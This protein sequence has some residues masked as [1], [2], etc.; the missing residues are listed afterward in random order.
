MTNS[1]EE[2]DKSPT[3]GQAVDDRPTTELSLYRWIVRNLGITIPHK[4]V[5][6]GHTSPWEIFHK[7]YFERPPLALIL[8]PRGGGKSYLSA[9]NI[10]LTSKWNSKHS[11][12]VL[13]GSLSQSEQI[14]NALGQII[15][16]EEDRSNI[17]PDRR[18]KLQ[19]SK[20]VYPNGSVVRILAASS[21]SVRGPHVP[22]LKLDEVDEIDND[23][24]EAALGMCMG[25]RSRSRRGLKSSQAITGSVVMTSTWHRPYGP[26]ADLVKRARAGELPLHSFCIFEVLEHCPDERSGKQ[27]ENCPKCL[28]K[29]Y[30][31]DVETGQPPKAKRA[32]GYYP[33]DSLIQ[34]IQGTSKR[35]FEADYLCNGPKSEGMWFPSFRRTCHVSEAAEYNPSLP[36]YLSIDPGVFC[37]AVFFQLHSYIH[38]GA[39]IEE[40]TIFADRMK[41]G[42]SA[43]FDGDEIAQLAELYC[44]K[45]VSRIFVDPAG[46]SRTGFGETVMQE[47]LRGDLKEFCK[48]E[49]WPRTGVIDGLSLLES[50]VD[51]ADERSSLRI[52]PRCEATIEAFEN[53]R[54]ARRSGQWQGYPEDPQHPFEEQIDAIRGGLCSLYPSG[55]I[56]Q[57]N[58]NRV[59]ARMVF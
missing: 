1:G 42:H 37:G 52:H 9:L 23:C 48:T 2:V 6:P 5:C 55:R 58:Y 4:S 44:S 40:L 28:L 12:C 38:E 41:E 34:K 17:D 13:G 33:I 35:T 36:V 53:Y 31:H 8:G 57:R 45:R 46:G 54:R 11:T 7:I 43:G 14:F 50:F 49:S 21:R 51:P 56:P 15:Q 59:A 25:R 32:K 24:R 18:M 20:V 16:E 47:M 39:K 29:P 19:R 27:Q 30:C 3:P 22:S 10:H 26:M